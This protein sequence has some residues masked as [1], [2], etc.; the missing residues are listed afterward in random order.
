[1]VDHLLIAGTSH[2]GKST[3]A[4]D[5]G[6]ALGW[7]VASTDKMGRH[8]G[9]PWENAPAHVLEF[10]QKMSKTAVHAFLLHHH[11]NLRPTIARFVSDMHQEQMPFVLEG[12]ALRPEYLFEFGSSAVCLVASDAW[13]RNRIEQN[14]AYDAQSPDL[15]VAIDAFTA[16]SLSENALFATAAKSAGIT[17][18]NAEDPN[19]VTKFAR[20]FV[21]R[22]RL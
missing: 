18:L 5:I 8:P 2:T 22:A 3:L 13:L 14:A 12:A 7:R 19:Q 15:Q 10:Y 20:D 1:M 17:T 6:S 9:R 4:T 21:D 16:R 11:Q